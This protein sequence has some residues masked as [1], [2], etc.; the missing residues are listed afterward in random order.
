M[1]IRATSPV[2]QQLPLELPPPVQ[3]IEVA[4]VQPA[5]P[6]PEPQATSIGRPTARTRTQV[7]PV[8]QGNRSVGTSSLRIN[9]RASSGNVGLNVAQ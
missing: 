4:P 5:P 6:A 3:P 1:C 7:N 2:A 8:R 9:R